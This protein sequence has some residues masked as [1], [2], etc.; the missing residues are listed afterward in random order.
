MEDLS[1]FRSSSDRF[2]SDRLQPSSLVQP[3]GSYLPGLG[4]GRALPGLGGASHQ[5]RMMPQ[6]PGIPSIVTTQYDVDRGMPPNHR[7]DD[8][9]F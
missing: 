6:I 7:F 5:S 8:I 9:F 1:F 4:L 2:P 3:M